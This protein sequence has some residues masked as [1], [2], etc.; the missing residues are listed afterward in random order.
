[1]EFPDALREWYSHSGRAALWQ[2]GDMPLLAPQDTSINSEHGDLKFI[3][4]KV[5][6]ALR[7]DECSQDDP[8]VYWITGPS[9][10]YMTTAP[11]VTQFV[12]GRAWAIILNGDTGCST[13]RANL[14]HPISMTDFAI[15]TTALES[16]IQ[17]EH[18]ENQDLLV[19]Q[20][21]MAGRYS[22]NVAALSGAAADS[23]VSQLPT[24]EYRPAD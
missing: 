7:V 15:K 24:T 17:M 21:P 10:S 12:L 11:S 4:G 19:R 8:P 3:D 1:M 22:V 20:L 5:P 2:Q 23:I 18:G 14:E 16:E 6:E 13:W 9:I